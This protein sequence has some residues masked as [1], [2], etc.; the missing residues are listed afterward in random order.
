MY[1]EAVKNIDAMFAEADVDRSGSIDFDEFC[2]Y[3]AKLD[4]EDTDEFNYILESF[5]R[6]L[7]NGYSKYLNM[8]FKLVGWFMPDMVTNIITS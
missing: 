3:M 1:A 8:P 7:S 2:R 5:D 4:R 6:S